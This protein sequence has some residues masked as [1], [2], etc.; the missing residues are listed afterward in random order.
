[1]QI[2]S[3]IGVHERTEESNSAST[4]L[5]KLGNQFFLSSIFDVKMM[6]LSL[7]FGVRLSLPLHYLPANFYSGNHL[8]S[9]KG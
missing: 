6:H 2:G 1:L 8:I 9:R 4:D 7:K 3:V 5:S